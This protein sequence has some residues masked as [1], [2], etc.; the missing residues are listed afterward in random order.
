MLLHLLRTAPP[1]DAHFEPEADEYCGAHRLGPRA[2][3]VGG[4]R[5]SCVVPPCSRSSLAPSRATGTPSRSTTSGRPTGW[6]R[7]TRAQADLG[8]INRPAST[9]SLTSTW[10]PR[11]T[12]GATLSSRR[13]LRDLE[14]A[15][16]IVRELQGPAAGDAAAGTANSVA[17]SS[18]RLRQPARKRNIELP[19]A[20][21]DRP[22]PWRDVLVDPARR[23]RERWMLWAVGGRRAAVR[24][25][26]PLRVVAREADRHP[27]IGAQR[28][29][30]MIHR[31]T[32]RGLR[33][34]DA[35]ARASWPDGDRD[36]PRRGCSWSCATTACC[37]AIRHPSRCSRA[38]CCSCRHDRRGAH[39]ARPWV[40]LGV[41]SFQPGELAKVAS[42]CSSFTTRHRARLAVD[43]GA[44][45]PVDVAAARPRPRPH[46][47]RP[48][49]LDARARRPARLGT[50]LLY[51]GLFL[52]MLYVATGRG[53]C[54]AGLALFVGGAPVASQALSYVGGRF[55]AWPTP[56]P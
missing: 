53:S 27:P 40:E 22:R 24:G 1:A 29:V 34:L 20:G 56:R 42:R 43:G 21:C 54:G 9:R 17:R 14:H 52:V 3:A 26:L 49:G 4:S 15:R 6:S 50:A 46:P 55:H 30:A 33:G 32:R 28:V 37:S 45:D 23:G 25:T 12:T 39:G 13:S 10:R 47:R 7:S 31:L 18:R 41:L 48:H 19:A 5:R 2:R 38:S 8:P 16:T 36:R 51:F 44:Q 11:L 35:T